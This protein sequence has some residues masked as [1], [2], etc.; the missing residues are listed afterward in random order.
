[1]NLLLDKSPDRM[2]QYYFASDN[3]RLEQVRPPQ[4]EP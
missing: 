3:Y 1:M 2:A 4:L